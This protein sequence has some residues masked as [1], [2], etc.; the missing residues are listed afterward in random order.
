MRY[1]LPFTS[2]LYCVSKATRKQLPPLQFLY[3]NIASRVEKQ[4]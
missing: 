2:I 4:K 1:V 3:A